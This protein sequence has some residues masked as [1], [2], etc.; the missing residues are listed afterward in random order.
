MEYIILEKV[1]VLKLVK[2]LPTFTG[3]TTAHHSSLFWVRRNQSTVFNLII[4][5]SILILS[6]YL[7]PDSFKWS[8]SF[9]LL[10]QNSACISLLPHTCP[11][12]RGP[13]AHARLIFGEQYK[14]RCFSV[15][16]FSA[17]MSRPAPWCLP[18]MWETKLHTWLTR[19]LIKVA[20]LF[21]IIC[22]FKTHWFL[23]F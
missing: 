17:Q 15:C 10:V 1:K 6:S 22:V 12:L 19:V 7:L 8:L 21:G 18:P 23:G 2:L 3:F 20:S 13:F 9:R 5:R 16:N 14:W 4:L 11:I